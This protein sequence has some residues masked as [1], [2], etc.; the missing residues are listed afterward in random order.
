MADVVLASHLAGA[1]KSAAEITAALKFPCIRSTYDLLS[2][3]GLSLVP[4]NS[5]QTCIRLMVAEKAVEAGMAVASAQ[6]RD[7]SRSMALALEELLLSPNT[8]KE[9][10]SAA[11]RRRK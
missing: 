7:P 8:F 2:R 11:E 3:Y 6:E 10:L 9:L 5:G 4:K 1:G